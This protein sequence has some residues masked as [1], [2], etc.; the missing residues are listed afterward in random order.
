MSIVVVGSIAFDDVITP[1]RTV[2]NALGGSALYFATAASLFTPVHIVGVVGDDFPL[3]ELSFLKSRGV[4]IEGIQVVKEGKTFRWAGKYERDMNKRTTTCLELNVFENFHPVL[5]ESCRKAHYVF[6]GNIDPDLQLEVLEQVESPEFAAADTIECYLED[7]PDRFREV[8]KK[9]DLLFI[10]DS[11]ALLFTGKH[12]IID[13]ARALLD[14]GPGYVIVKKG[15][16]GSLLVSHDIFFVVPAYPVENVIDPT[17][18]GDCYAG[19]VMGYIAKMND[20]NPQ[21]LKMAVVLGGLVASFLVEG[22]SFETLKG[23]VFGTVE[24]RMKLFRSMISF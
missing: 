21:T 11:E 18:A 19:G 1:Q 20:I 6:L 22:F 23:L 24:E 10:N 12:S 17:G 8:L 4:N 3:V 7:K 13:A 14:C 15:E 2:R 16:H 9:I 5:P